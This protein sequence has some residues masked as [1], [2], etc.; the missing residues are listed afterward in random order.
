MA[1]KWSFSYNSLE[2]IV[3]LKHNILITRFIRMEPKCSAIKGLA[4]VFWVRCGS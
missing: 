4:L 3:P 2:K 1:L